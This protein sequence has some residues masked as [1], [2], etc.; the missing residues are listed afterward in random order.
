MKD[1]KRRLQNGELKMKNAEW[2]YEIRDWE[3]GVRCW[4]LPG[5]FIPHPSSLILLG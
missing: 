2:A 1:E 5:T 3:L 4:M